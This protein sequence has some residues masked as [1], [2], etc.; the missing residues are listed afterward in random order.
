MGHYT[1]TVAAIVG[2]LARLYYGVDAIPK[3]WLDK[4]T[5]K[6]YVAELCKKAR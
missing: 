5:Q 1:D 4:I 6:E 2:G 3:D